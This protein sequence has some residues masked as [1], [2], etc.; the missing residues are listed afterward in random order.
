MAQ[1]GG[2]PAA[3]VLHDAFL[4]HHILLHVDRDAM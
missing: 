1:G 4:L 3:T 2:A